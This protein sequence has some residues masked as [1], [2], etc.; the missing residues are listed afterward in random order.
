M[1]KTTVIIKPLITEKTTH[2]QN[3]RNTYAFQVRKDANKNQIKDAVE[4]L[5]NV[6]VTDVRTQV[7][8]GKPRRSRFK[9]TTTS[10]FK[11][12]IV[13]LDEASKIELF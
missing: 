1:D 9:M 11:R 3:V 13:V 10:D 2:Q 4:S 6:K 8:K 12:A 7:R 5:Y